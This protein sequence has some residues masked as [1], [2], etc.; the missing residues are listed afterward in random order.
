MILARVACLIQK[1]VRLVRSQALVPKMDRQ[2]GQ[3]AQ[4]GGEEAAL[5]QPA[6]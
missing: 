2:P 1:L 6:N 3:F 5:W 4:F